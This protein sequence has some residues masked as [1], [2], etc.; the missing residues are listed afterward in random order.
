MPSITGEFAAAYE[1]FEKDIN[2]ALVE[3][4]DQLSAGQAETEADSELQPMFQRA[5]PITPNPLCVSSEAAVVMRVGLSMGEASNLHHQTG[6][7]LP[8]PKGSGGE[9]C[10]K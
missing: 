8:G 5:A 1:N 9:R 10:N 4:T 6:C 7:M 3:A 2:I